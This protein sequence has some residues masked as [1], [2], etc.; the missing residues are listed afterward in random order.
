MSNL[1]TCP[2]CG[3]DL[4]DG[5]AR[6]FFVRLRLYDTRS[7]NH[8]DPIADSQEGLAADQIGTERICG[9]PEIMV[10]ASGLAATF[11]DHRDLRG[12]DHET[13][14]RK[15]RGVRPTL[16]RTGGR[17][18][19]RIEYDTPESFTDGRTAPRFVARI[20]LLRDDS[21]QENGA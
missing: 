16:S 11:H 9:L 3:G 4:R 21:A 6:N 10:T 8:D 12:W 2:H 18:T 15:I 20:D 5:R 19:I 13:V 1:A 17:G 14:Q 7:A